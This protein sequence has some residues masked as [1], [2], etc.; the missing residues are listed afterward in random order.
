MSTLY[1]TTPHSLV[2]RDG[3]TLLVQ[4]PEEG[5]GGRQKRQVRVPL[6]KVTQVVVYGDVTLTSPALTALLNQGAEICFCS[7]SGRFHGRLA[8]PEGKNSLVR[9]EQHRAHDDP[10]RCLTLARAFVAGKLAN[11]RAMLLRANR[12]RSDEAVAQA[13]ESLKGI[14]TQ[15]EALD[16]AGA[17]PA[18]DPSR[19]QE[20]TLMGSLLGLEG[21]GSA[22]Y[23]GVLA[24][25]L[26]EDWGFARRQR[27]PP[28]DPVNAL[29][30]FGYT[31][32]ANQAAAAVQVVGLDPYIGFL[33]SS[34]YGR[35]ALALDI[36]E[37]FRP[38]IVDSVVLTLLNTGQLQRKDVTEELGAWRLTDRGRQTFLARYEERLDTEIE[39][40]TFGYKATYRRCLELEARLVAKWL[41]GDIAVYRP[42]TVR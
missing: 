15:V 20:G 34:Q 6:M 16:P 28:R 1:L 35:P 42:F 11:M 3:E 19:P 22:C 27:R 18:P 24:R 36:M 4:I 41:M 26:N 39:H 12:K 23:F 9:L 2:R 30:S 33:H 14:L 10:R 32:L 8:P 21:T 25:I 7:Q 13:V 17:K 31:L 38:L 29:L 40:P 5:E 37:A